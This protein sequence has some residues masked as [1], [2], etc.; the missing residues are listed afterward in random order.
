MEFF[1]FSS[2]RTPREARRVSRAREIRLRWT[3][4]DGTRQEALLSGFAAICAV[5]TVFFWRYVPETKG[6]SLEEIARHWLA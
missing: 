6:K 5:A 4:L 2:L 3:D 1:C